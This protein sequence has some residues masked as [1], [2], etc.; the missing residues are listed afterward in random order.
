MPEYKLRFRGHK[1]V[2]K[3]LAANRRAAIAKFVKG[4]TYTAMNV[5]VVSPRKHQIVRW[6]DSCSQK[7]VGAG[8]V[9]RLPLAGGAGVFLCRR[10]WAKE[11]RWRRGRNKRLSK[12][13]RFSI[14]KFPA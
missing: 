7:F 12:E 14:R 11:M 2:H 5:V 6:C 1:T 13:A 10:C 9:R 4:S 3:V 8:K